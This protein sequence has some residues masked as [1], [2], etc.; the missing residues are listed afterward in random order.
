VRQQVEDCLERLRADLGGWLALLTHDSGTLVAW[1][2][3]GDPAAMARYCQARADRDADLTHLLM[4]ECD[5]PSQARTVRV[6]SHSALPA[7]SDPAEIDRLIGASVGDGRS[8]YRLD[9]DAIHDLRPDL[10]LSPGSMRRLRG[11]LR[12]RQ[13]SLGRPGRPGRGRLL[14]P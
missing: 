12:A 5:W 2:G 10:V 11:P 1:T 6:V 4:R 7:A 8:I 13:P 14:R 9:I 3:P